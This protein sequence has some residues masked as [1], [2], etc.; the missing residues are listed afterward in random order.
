MKG[1]AFINVRYTATP[2]TPANPSGAAPQPDRA[3]CRLLH[4]NDV[5]SAGGAPAFRRQACLLEKI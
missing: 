3:A 4:P 1:L 5:G 2:G